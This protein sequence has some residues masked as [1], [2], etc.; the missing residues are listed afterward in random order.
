MPDIDP[1]KVK[2][3]G[4]EYGRGP[5]GGIYNRQGGETWESRYNRNVRETEQRRAEEARRRRLAEE[6]ERR[7]Y[8]PQSGGGYIPSVPMGGGGFFTG[9]GS[10]FT[11]IGVFIIGLPAFGLLMA[12]LGA[13]VYFGPTALSKVL[14]FLGNVLVTV[15]TVIW[16]II[17]MPFT[18]WPHLVSGLKASFCCKLELILSGGVLLFSVFHW[19]KQILTD[20]IPYYIAFIG[21]VVLEFLR[22]FSGSLGWLEALYNGI[23]LSLPV[24]LLLYIIDKIYERIN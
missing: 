6:E 2:Y 11:G 9:V 16:K 3:N 21:L 18:A 4:G 19:R 20:S 15:V 22:H 17:S 10:L 24:M 7:R 1:R 13:V 23:C 12:I 8:R 5:D 14:E